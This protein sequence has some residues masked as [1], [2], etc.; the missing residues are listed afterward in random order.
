MREEL[1]ARADARM[2]LGQE[3]D[4][5]KE[6]ENLKGQ[7]EE[8]SNFLDTNQEAIGEAF[9]KNSVLEPSHIENNLNY[10]REN[11]KSLSP[12]LVSHRADILL[13]HNHLADRLGAFI[14]ADCGGINRFIQHKS[15]VPVLFENLKTSTTD[16]A[17]YLKD[18]LGDR[19]FL[20]DEIRTYDGQVLH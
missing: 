16:F 4:R 19:K 18:L 6:L 9:G 8:I 10:I 14:T 11:I 7:V 3:S 1:I 2:P 12:L 17:K 20:E 15:F 5:E 13:I